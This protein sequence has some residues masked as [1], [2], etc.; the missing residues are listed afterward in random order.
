MNF[1]VILLTSAQLRT[2]HRFSE[3][4]CYDEMDDDMFV[5]TVTLLTCLVANNNPVVQVGQYQLSER[6]RRRE[7]Y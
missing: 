3:L 1:Y 4:V 2:S 5:C 6:A 7:L